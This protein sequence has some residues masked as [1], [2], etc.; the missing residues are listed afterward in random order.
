MQVREAKVARKVPNV[1]TEIF[2]LMAPALNRNA[3]LSSTVMTATIGALRILAVNP[4][5]EKSV[6]PKNATKMPTAKVVPV[7][8][9]SAKIT[10]TTQV[11]VRA[12]PNVTKVK[13]V[14]RL[15]ANA[16]RLHHQPL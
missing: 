15:P 6:Q 3:R 10:A 13:A 16:P 1:T 8:T 4:A 12:T 2:V 5:L 11:A 9:T 7:L 14:T